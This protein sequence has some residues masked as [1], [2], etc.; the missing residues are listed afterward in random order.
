MKKYQTILADPPWEPSISKILGQKWTHINK[1]SPHKHY[2]VMPVEE[3][4]SMHIPSAQQAHL[5]IWALNQHVDWA[6]QVARAWGFEP[7]QMITWCK[8]GLGTGRFQCNTEQ[9]VLCR[10]GSRHGNPFGMTNG[11]WFQWPRG[12]HSLKPNAFYDLVE[13]V[14]PAPYL[15]L[16][17]RFKRLGWDSWGNE[18]DSDINIEEYKERENERT[19]WE[20]YYNKG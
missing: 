16:F 10:K 17:A 12:V 11:T 3:I 5:W 1:A 14:S 7:W 4:C 2:N 15:E 13:R 9:V 6:Y 18:V 19:L 8:P 20:I